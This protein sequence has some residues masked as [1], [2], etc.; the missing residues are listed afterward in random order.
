MGNLA[1][2]VRE[3]ARVGGEA[4][5][6]AQPLGPAT[7]EALALGQ[8]GEGGI[9]EGG[10]H[11]GLHEELEGARHRA[12]LRGV[13]E[14]EAAAERGVGEVAPAAGLGQPERVPAAGVVADAEEGDAGRDP[15]ALLGDVALA[16][17]GRGDGPA[18][19]EPLGAL[20][21]RAQALEPPELVLRLEVGRAASEEQVDADARPALLL[22]RLVASVEHHADLGGPARRAPVD[23]DGLAL[24]GLPVAGEGLGELPAD[25]L[26]VRCQDDEAA[27]A[28]RRQLGGVLAQREGKGDEQGEQPGDAE[29]GASLG[30]AAGRTTASAA[31]AARPTSLPTAAGPSG[32]RRSTWSSP[33]AVATVS[34]ARWPR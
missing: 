4:L 12:A 34:W 17:E 32:L 11:L 18:R 8:V 1:R 24:A 25:G 26:A 5:D 30:H 14:G 19:G 31:S 2:V 20:V 33:S 15:G 28:A 13:G 9:G 3:V 7:G 29:D 6:E 21:E 10:L 27:R 22:G 16:G 23:V